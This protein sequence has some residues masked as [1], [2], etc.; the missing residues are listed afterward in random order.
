PVQLQFAPH[1]AVVCHRV[2]AA[3]WKRLDQ[4]D[5]HAGSLDVSQELVSQTDAVTGAFNK[6]RKI[7]QHEG[8]LVTDGNEAQ[9]AM[10]RGEGIVRDPRMSPSQPAEQGRLARVRQPYQAH[11][12]Y[13]LQLQNDPP[14]FT[15]RAR[16]RLPRRPVRRGDEG[17][18]AP[19]SP[20]TMGRRDLL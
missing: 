8:P 4:M 7:G 17:Q 6:P 3:G 20:P 18:V 9:V 10:L 19:A 11:V 14:F 5:E 1:D 2:A 15:G 12:S 16:L 13:H